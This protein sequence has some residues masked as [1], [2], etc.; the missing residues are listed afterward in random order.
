[1]RVL[2]LGLN[3][4]YGQR[5]KRLVCNFCMCVLSYFLLHWCAFYRFGC[6]HIVQCAAFRHRRSKS[7]ATDSSMLTD[8]VQC[9]QLEIAEAALATYQGTNVSVVTQLH[10]HTDS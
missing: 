9:T 3:T 10:P 8:A 1:M 2:F 4:P 7:S 6:M 5:L